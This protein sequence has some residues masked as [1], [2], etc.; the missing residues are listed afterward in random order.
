MKKDNSEKAGA[1][2]KYASL[3]QFNAIIHWGHKI[4]SH[5]SLY[6]RTR[7][8]DKGKNEYR[9]STNN[10]IICILSNRFTKQLYLQDLFQCLIYS[11]NRYIKFKFIDK[12]IC[13][14]AVP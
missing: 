5:S 3:Q 4:V 14:S 8:R 12:K 7:E 1:S 13:P 2:S 10:Y 6:A 9:A 11:S